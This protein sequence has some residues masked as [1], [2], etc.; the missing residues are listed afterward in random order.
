M[1][2]LERSALTIELPVVLR[3]ATAADLPKLEWYGQFAHFRNLFR[4][5]FREQQQGHRLMLIADCN[6]FP[7]GQVFVQLNSNESRLDDSQKRA[8]L[9]SLRVM[10]MFRGK[11]IGT[12]LIQ[13]AETTVSGMGYHSI[14][15][16]AAKDNPEARR[17]YERMGYHVIAEDSGH[18][19]YLDHRG[20]VQYVHEP[21]WVLEKRLYLR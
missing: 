3:L 15:I 12:R 16:A 14:T 9:Y 18:W 10:E 5:T 11:G 6:D 13:E 4:R 21:C 20:I 17:L 19:S 1:T 2:A 7:I 8:Y